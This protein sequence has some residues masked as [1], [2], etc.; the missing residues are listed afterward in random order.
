MLVSNFRDSFQSMQYAENPKNADM[1][2]VFNETITFPTMT[3]CMK[4]DQAWSHF[5]L[6]DVTLDNVEVDRMAE[7]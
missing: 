1:S 4:R 5:D 6:D 3:F 2:I 7:V